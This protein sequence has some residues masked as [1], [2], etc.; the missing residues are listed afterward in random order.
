MGKGEKTAKPEVL[1]SPFLIRLHHHYIIHLLLYF[2]DF[3]IDYILGRSPRDQDSNAN[4]TTNE[5]KNLES[6]RLS[7][8][9]TI[10]SI[11]GESS[12]AGSRTSGYSSVSHTDSRVGRGSQ[13]SSSPLHTANTNAESHDADEREVE[14]EERREGQS[15]QNLFQCRYCDKVYRKRCSLISHEQ[16]HNPMH[17]CYHCQKCFSRK[18]L[19]IGHMRVHTNERPYEC[20]ECK[21]KFA[22]PSNFRAH[23]Q[24]HLE[25]KRHACDTCSRTFSRKS[26]LRNHQAKCTP[27]PH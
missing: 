25:R 26:Q 6:T 12:S 8:S 7:A 21:R 14:V 24:T 27:P 4:E 18:W 3:S 17:R 11:L 19:L 10:A 1:A 9:F 13:G 23:L 15:E 16:S 5:T 22:D 20:K 2:V